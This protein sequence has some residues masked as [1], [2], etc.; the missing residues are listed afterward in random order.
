MI[1]HQNGARKLIVL[2]FLLPSGPQFVFLFIVIVVFVVLTLFRPEG[3]LL[4]PYKTLKLNNFK[5]V[6]AM[7]TNFSGFS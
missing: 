3:G 5:T 6:T 7:T 2:L 4:R 1:E